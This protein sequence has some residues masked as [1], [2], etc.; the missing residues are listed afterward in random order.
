MKEA[1]SQPR[2]KTQNLDDTPKAHT[3]STNE[4]MAIM[5]LLTVSTKKKIYSE[6][7]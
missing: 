4:G 3:Y 6:R 2:K 7:K 1:G 5:A